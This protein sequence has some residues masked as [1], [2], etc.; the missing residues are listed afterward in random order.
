MNIK[1]LFNTKKKIE[2]DSPQER[3]R[4][5]RQRLNELSRISRLFQAHPYISIKSVV[6]TPPEKYFIA[7]RVDG[8]M[9]IGTSIEARN[10]HTLELSLSQRYPSEPPT[11]RMITSLFHPNVSGDKIDLTGIWAH[12]TNLADCIVQFA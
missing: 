4:R 5:M 1:D 8:L 7:Y 10:E 3:E 11:A 12:E 2:S 9:Q 6:G